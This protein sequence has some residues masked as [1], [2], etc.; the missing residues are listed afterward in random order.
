MIRFQTNS[1]EVA[2]DLS[3]LPTRLN[4][5]ALGALRERVGPLWVKRA[6]EITESERGVASGAYLSGFR[7]QGFTSAAQRGVEMVNLAA[8]A[9]EVEWGREAGDPV[10]V[11]EIRQWLVDKGQWSDNPYAIRQAIIEKGTMARKNY[12]GLRVFERTWDSTI[13]DVI[14]IVDESRD[15]VLGVVSS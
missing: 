8:H 15:E 6:R 11:E 13:E 12:G 1:R 9:P 2:R 5:A 14:N 10:T 3:N 7:A 4:N